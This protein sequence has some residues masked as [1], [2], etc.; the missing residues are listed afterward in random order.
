VILHVLFVVYVV[1]MFAWILSTEGAKM[2]E[3]ECPHEK[4]RTQLPLDGTLASVSDTFP[5]RH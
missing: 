3:F 1:C 2:K 5:E 4:E